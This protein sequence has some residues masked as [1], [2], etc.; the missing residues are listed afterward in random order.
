M[1]SHRRTAGARTP[2]A[3]ETDK[4]LEQYGCGSDPVHRN[5]RCA[6][7]APSSVR[8][9]RRSR[10]GG[11][12][13]ALRGRG[14]L[15]AGR[16]VTAVGAHG[17]DVRAPESQA[18][19]LPVHGVPPRAL[20]GQQHHEPAAR[21]SGAARGRGERPR[22]AGPARA[23]ARRRSGQRRAGA[24]GGVLPRLDG[25]D[26]AAGHG[27]RAAV[28][29]RAL[30]ADHP[31]RLAAGAA[32]QLAASAGPVGSRPPVREGGRQAELFL[33]GARRDLATHRRP[34]VEPDRAPL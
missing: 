22:L 13:R 31:G 20:A 25:H 6:L 5:A 26:A 21:S 33:R 19:L 4:L 24:P 34:T 23:G 28:R 9:R 14:P 8:Q 3:A 30:Q 10:R 11:R 2:S 12:A 7:R 29:V 32:R 18:R 27:L 16:P 1:T 17:E 15:R